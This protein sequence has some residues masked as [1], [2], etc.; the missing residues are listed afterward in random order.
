MKKC[1]ISGKISDLTEKEYNANFAEA[2]AEVIALGFEPVSPLSFPHLHDKS[3]L[4]YMKEDI[5]EMMKC[6]L[7]FAQ[8]NW[9]DSRGAKIE[10]ELADSIE[11]FILYQK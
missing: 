5:S 2:E 3:W 1:Y 6:D 10:I 7:V 4:N 9:R 8:R 11:M